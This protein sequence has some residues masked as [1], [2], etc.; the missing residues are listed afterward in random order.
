MC[1]SRG[2][3]VSLLQ[4]LS[5]RVKVVEHMC[6][7]YSLSKSLHIYGCSINIRPDGFLMLLFLYRLQCNHGQR[8]LG[9]LFQFVTFT[10]ALNSNL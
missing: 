3:F 5:A 4:L 10:C 7:S 9:I 2:T 1:K 6:F 8:Y